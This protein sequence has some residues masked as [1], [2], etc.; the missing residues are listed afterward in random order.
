MAQKTFHSNE[1]NYNNRQ[2]AVK[3]YIG[4]ENVIKVGKGLSFYMLSYV[5][6]SCKHKKSKNLNEE[7]IAFQ[8]SIKSINTKYSISFLNIL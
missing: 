4:Q 2:R 3:G 5:S 7:K 6:F 1:H 8:H